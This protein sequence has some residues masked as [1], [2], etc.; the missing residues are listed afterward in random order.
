VIADFSRWLK[1]KRINVQALDR[2]V[3]D[4]FLRLR[5]VG[6]QFSHRQRN[7]QTSASKL[8]KRALELEAFGSGLTDQL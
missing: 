4:R 7:C 5:P 3:V 8:V 1:Q 6:R 2:E